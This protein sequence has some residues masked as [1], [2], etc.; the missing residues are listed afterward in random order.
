[1]TGIGNSRISSNEPNY[2]FIYS[3][4]T[5]DQSLSSISIPDETPAAVGPLAIDPSSGKFF[6]VGQNESNHLP[7]I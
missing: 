6:V 3:L 5:S 4:S 7:L 2:P 1:M